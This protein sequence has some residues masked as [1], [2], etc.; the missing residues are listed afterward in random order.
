MNLNV[1]QM[2]QGL[3]KRRRGFCSAKGWGGGNRNKIDLFILL[4]E[5]YFC[6]QNK[7]DN[8]NTTI[9]CIDLRG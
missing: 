2:D 3:T 6:L 1:K 4:I 8:L 7:L 9:H 5:T